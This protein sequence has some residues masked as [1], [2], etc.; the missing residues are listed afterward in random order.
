M[1]TKEVMSVYDGLYKKGEFRLTW[2]C[3]IS[4]K[5]KISRF[6]SLFIDCFKSYENLNILELGAGDGFLTELILKKLNCKKYVAT[7]LSAEGVKKIKKRKIK[8]FKM[9][10]EKLKFSDNSFDIVCCFDVMHHVNNP[11]Q[12]ASEMVRVAKKKVFLIEP[13]GLCFLR[14]LLEKTSKYKSTGE[15]SYSPRKYNSFFS[16]GEV[17]KFFVKPFFCIPSF[18][19][20][21][22]IRPVVWTGR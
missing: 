4:L 17:R 7:D 18:I 11:K 15:N 20:P 3:E 10:A 8:A 2:E 5:Y 14:K 13:N 12:M 6:V 16:S 19:P 22:L 21:M 9:D 1:K